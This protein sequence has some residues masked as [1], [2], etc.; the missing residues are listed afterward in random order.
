M[1]S[2]ACAAAAATTARWAGD[3]RITKRHAWKLPP[4]GAHVAASKQRRRESSS[5]GSSV[6][7]RIDRA[8]DI[9]SHKSSVPPGLLTTSTPSAFRTGDDLLASTRRAAGG[10]STGVQATE[11]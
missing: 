10:N 5:T 4:D 3:L 7:R 1:T 9:A 2:S 6:K 8:V 11:I